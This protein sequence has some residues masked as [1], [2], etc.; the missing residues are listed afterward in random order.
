MACVTNS[1]R[2]EIKRLRQ[3]C[4]ILAG[5]PSV[6]V[7]SHSMF[8]TKARRRNMEKLPQPFWKICHESRDIRFKHAL[9]HSGQLETTCDET[10]AIT[11]ARRNLR[12]PRLDLGPEG[13]LGKRGVPFTSPLLA[14]VLST[15]SRGCHAFGA[16]RLLLLCSAL[17]P[18]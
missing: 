1:S 16:A 14:T 17:T 8:P 5:R 2:V 6:C 11:A 7:R 15:V 9:Q 10:R 3:G 18:L 12:E 13:A 4:L